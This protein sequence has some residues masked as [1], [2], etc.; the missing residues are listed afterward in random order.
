MYNYLFLFSDALEQKVLLLEQTNEYSKVIE[1]CDIMLKIDPNCVF[2][3]ITKVI[4]LI[5]V[6]FLYGY[7]WIIS[8]G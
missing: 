3:I 2:A 5:V 7:K 8:T 6:A 1:T 4:I